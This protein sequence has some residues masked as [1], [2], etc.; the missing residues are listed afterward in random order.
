MDPLSD[1][2]SLLRPRGTLSACL[3]AGAAWAIR[4]PGQ[5]GTLKCGA[6]ATG[7]CWLSVDGEA[8]AVRL[9]AGD[10]FLL[11]SG[12]P[13][14]LASDLR[15]PAQDAH[16]IF[17]GARDGVATCDGGGETFV[18]SSRFALAGVQA[19]LLLDLLPP[20]VH[21]QGG[22]GHAALRWSVE[23]MAEELRDRRP[24]GLLVAEHL[25][26][27]VLVQALRRHLEDGP[28]G[29][30]GWL[31]ALADPRLGAAMAA[32]HA[33]PARRW[34]LQSLAAC[35]GMSR[36]VFALRFREAVGGPPMD[37]LT[38]WRMALAADRLAR[39]TDPVAVVAWSVGYASE[40]AFSTAFK[41]VMGHP[42][43]RYQTARPVGDP[44]MRDR[45]AEFAE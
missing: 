22:Q 38:R 4:F 16:A 43:R 20:V 26:H 19:A 5:E 34:T 41:R 10:C 11:P 35:A 18:V 40:T 31:F 3:D 25:A 37:Y 29:G 17:P 8:C 39:T 36:S 1:I 44:L 42:P 45:Q 21:V 12:R 7:A 23:R 15:L 30:V 9:E 13:F 28:R 2:L 32:L 27:M 6:V 33:D 14:R 24:G